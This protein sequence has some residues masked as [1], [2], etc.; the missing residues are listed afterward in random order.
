[1]IKKRTKFKRSPYK[2]LSTKNI[3]TSNSRLPKI[4]LDLNKAFSKKIPCIAWMI[5][6]TLQFLSDKTQI[7]PVYWFGEKS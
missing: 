3:P 6:I 7:T 2:V 5:E 1:M 4:K